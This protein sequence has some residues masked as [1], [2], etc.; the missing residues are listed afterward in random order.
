MAADTGTCFICCE[1]ESDNRPLMFACT[2][3]NAMTHAECLG[4]HLLYRSL[5]GECSIC[6]G[7]LTREAT[8]GALRVALEQSKAT[9]G[10]SHPGTV[11]IA[12]RLANVLSNIGDYEDARAVIRHQMEGPALSFASE[13]ICQVELLSVNAREGNQ[14]QAK[15]PT[16]LAETLAN[17]N[18]PR[19]LIKTNLIGAACCKRQRAFKQAW[20]HVN[21]AHHAAVS[22][23]P[24][25]STAFVKVLKT[26]AKIFA[27]EG[28]NFAVVTTLELIV[29][30]L[31]SLNK[32]DSSKFEAALA[33][34]ALARV[35]AGQEFGPAALRDIYCT[36]RRAPPRDYRRLNALRRVHEYILQFTA[37]TRRI[38]RKRSFQ[39]I[40]LRAKQPTHVADEQDCDEEKKEEVEEHCK[41]TVVSLAGEVIITTQLPPFA[42]VRELRDQV[43]SALNWPC[44][45][46]NL[47]TENGYKMKEYDFIGQ[48]LATTARVTVVKRSPNPKPKWK[49]LDMDALRG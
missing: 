46:L 26:A 34:L 21:A 3:C 13:M 37:P 43:A 9:L 18:I 36:L 47:I 1:G 15:T 35:D 24:P 49:P 30:N 19:L 11:L 22:T 28:N 29:Q 6:S 32:I 45:R 48:H 10:P 31:R 5:R 16:R 38:S 41:I 8:S 44:Y 40:E 23:Q 20:N 2:V 17:C 39:S 12:T 14:C 27:A 33:D 42:V 4:Q 25:H 7:T